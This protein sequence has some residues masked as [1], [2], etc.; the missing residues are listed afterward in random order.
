MNHNNLPISLS[1]ISFNV[2]DSDFRPTRSSL[3]KMVF[4][5]RHDFIIS[6]PNPILIVRM[7]LAN[8]RCLCGDNSRGVR[9]KISVFLTDM[10][11][12]KLHSS[13]TT[14]VNIKSGALSNSVAIYLPIDY[15]NVDFTHSYS[16]SIRDN[17]TGQILGDREVRLFRSYHS[18]A[19]I[20]EMLI[21]IEGGVMPDC[22]PILCTSFEAELLTYHGVRFNLRP[23]ESITLPVLLPE[24][25]IRIYFP[26]GS[27]DSNFVD[28]TAVHDEA[29]GEDSYQVTA[30]FYMT[31]SKKGICYA[32]LICLDECI[33]G[34]VFNTD[35]DEII[36]GSWS[37]DNLYFLEEYSLEEATKRY[38]E[39][40]N[41]ENISSSPID[42]DVDKMLDEF[43]SSQIETE[44]TVE[45]TPK[46][47]EH[48]GIS[49]LS[50]LKNLTGLRSVKEKL[51][52]YEK[53]VLFN[54]MRQENEL[55]T[56]KL[57]LHAMFLGSPG[58]GKTTV[59]KRMGLM[60]RRA[61]VLSNGHVVIKERAMLLG[62]HYS[63]EE[64][65][66]LKAIEEA[67]GGILFI[68]EA[69]QL[70][71]PNDPRD[72]GKFVIETLMTALADESKRDWMLIL[73]GYTDE[74]RH[75]FDMNP[76]LKSRIPDSNIY[77]FDD[78]SENELV[79]IAEHHLE[80]NGYI[81]TEEARSALINRLS[82]D[83][84]NRDRSFGNARHVINMIQ[85]EILPAMASRVVEAGK[86][87]PTALSVI[88]YADI[89]QPI[90]R[91]R[92]KRPE[93]GYR[94]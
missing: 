53:L 12:N 65:N 20:T 71:Q 48:E 46:P 72:P 17:K 60:L 80:R 58:T 91:F 30:P 41:K 50:S 37:S 43:M 16:V 18:H 38:N 68:D 79:E 11:N 90:T 47:E 86:F 49:L 3:S 62:K 29:T 23:N 22:S 85:T 44:E 13:A 6:K 32:E 36:Y 78:F 8:E 76:G 15:D 4:D 24:M 93:I 10:S 35:G 63:D 33:A 67:Q 19:F 45:P 2:P 9:R 73:A 42:I 1:Q 75:M 89:P 27:I 88:E 69:Y 54:K 83:Y 28:P 57:P 84:N 77:I 39:S 51:L 92:S 5:N 14:T 52:S 40:I 34:F 55:P 87:D 61:G 7:V 66:T 25:E 26:D 21:P 70:Y 82:C 74:M 94:A 81:M 59:A 64:T 31:R 56:M